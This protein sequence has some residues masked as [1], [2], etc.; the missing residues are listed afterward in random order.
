MNLVVT[1]AAGVALGFALNWAAV[2][3]LLRR[4]RALPRGPPDRRP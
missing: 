4:V 2:W 3:Y 1:L